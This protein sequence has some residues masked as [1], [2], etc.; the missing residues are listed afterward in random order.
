MLSFRNGLAALVEDGYILSIEEDTAYIPQLRTVSAQRRVLD[1]SNASPLVSFEYFHSYNVNI[2]EGEALI[3]AIYAEVGQRVQKGDVLAV[4]LPTGA[5]R[6]EHELHMARQNLF[7]FDESFQDE[8]HRRHVELTNARDELVNADAAELLEASLR[9]QHV[10]ASYELFAIITS[11]ARQPLV[12]RLEYLEAF[13]IEVQLK[14]PMDGMVYMVHPLA[15]GF[16]VTNPAMPGTAWL[17]ITIVDESTLYF[18]LNEMTETTARASGIPQGFTA[19]LYRFGANLTLAVR[20]YDE[21]FFSSVVSDPF[22]TGERGGN[23]SFLLEPVDRDAFWEWVYENEIN[24]SSTSRVMF[25]IDL[26]FPH[27]QSELVLP[28]QSVRTSGGQRY[29]ILYEAGLTRRQFVTVGRTGRVD[30][31][32]GT[33]VQV[34]SGLTEGELVVLG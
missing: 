11:T 9:M 6:L 20:D 23:L 12:D 7:R 26:Y 8:R 33:Y 22:V 25:Y 19:Y 1:S 14:A 10:E 16:R 18:R 17:G 21:V 30:G 29:V 32:S 31:Q 24:M 15:E 34:L 13:T 3:V 5:I 28:S 4:I 2:D 27:V